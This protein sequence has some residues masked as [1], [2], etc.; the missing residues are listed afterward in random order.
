[1]EWPLNDTGLDTTN[2]AL[3]KIGAWIKRDR[4]TGGK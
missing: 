3:L 2:K 1:M 4:N